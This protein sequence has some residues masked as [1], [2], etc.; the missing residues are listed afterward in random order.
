[1]TVKS[2]ENDIKSHEL[3]GEINLIFILYCKRESS[4][5]KGKEAHG[6]NKDQEGNL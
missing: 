5:M 4:V 1:M 2:K 3:T 6:V